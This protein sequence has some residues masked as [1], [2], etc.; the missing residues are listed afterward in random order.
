MELIGEKQN[1]LEQPDVQKYQKLCPIMS[2]LVPGV[3]PLSGE[4]EGGLQLAP[5]A[6][7]ECAKWSNG[8]E[9][10]DVTTARAL[11]MIAESFKP[12]RTVFTR[13]RR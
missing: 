1:P 12:G 6:R 2:G 9:C 13:E 4:I 5:C 3:N 10:S 7:D 8:E 11:D